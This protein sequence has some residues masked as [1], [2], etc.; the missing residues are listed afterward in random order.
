MASN[1]GSMVLEL[2]ANFA[3]F[4]SDMG[5]AAYIA[6]QNAEKMQRA[7][8]GAVDNVSGSLMHLAGNIVAAFSVEKLV[9]FGKRAI[10]TAD[11]V[12][13]MAQKIGISVESLSALQ[14]QARLSNTANEELQVGLSKLAKAAADA[15]GGGKQNQAVFAALGVSVKDAAGNL[16]PMADLLQDVAGKFATYR[17]SAAKTADAQL[18]F[19]KSG[20]NLIPYLNEL[21]QKSLPEVIAQAEQFGSVISTKTAKQAEA[22]NDNLT[23][24]KLEAEGFANAV[25]KQLLPNLVDLSN[26]MVEAGKT[27]DSYASSASTVADGV[28]VFVFSLIAAKEVVAALATGVFAFFDAVSTVFDS[29]GK[30]VAAWAETTAKAIKAAFSLDSAGLDA[31]DKEFADRVSKIGKGV[32]T[33]LKGA[34]EGLSGGVTD[35]VDRAKIAYNSLFNST[36]AAGTSAEKAG[37]KFGDA[38][39]PIIANAAAAD[40]A[41]KAAQKIAADYLDMQKVLDGLAAKLGGPYDKAWSEYAAAID[42]AQRASAKYTA[43]GVPLADV[44][45]FIAEATELATERFRELTSAELNLNKGMEAASQE[46][47]KQV[48][49]IG[50]T[51]DE[52]AIEAEYQKLLNI[53]LKE[54]SAVMGPLTEEEQKRLEGLHGM[55]VGLVELKKSTDLSVEA[56]KG[57]QNIWSQA[58]DSI[59][60]TFSKVLIEGGSFMKGLADIAKQVVEQI[61]AYFA[62]LAIINPILNSVFGGQAGFS[63]LPMWSGAA[64]G[65]GYA[66][67]GS[68]FGYGS[69]VGALGGA[70]AGAFAGYNAFKDAGGGLSGAAAGAAYGVGTFA[71]GGALSAGIAASAAG[72]ISAGL[73][74]GFAAIPVV[75]WVALAAMGLNMITGGGLFGTA[76]KAYGSEFNVGV[77]EGGAQASALVDLK[78]KKALFGG[79]YY[80]TQSTPVDQATQDGLNSFFSGL[81]D[82]ANAQAKAF[83]EDVGQIV[84]G[85]FHETFDKAGKMLTEVSTVAGVQ[86]KE[87]IDDF[88]KRVIGETLLGNMGAA[89]EEASKIAEQWRQSA[90]DLLAGSQFLAQAQLDINQG[91]GL[92][93]EDTLTQ[94]TTFVQGMEAQGESLIQTYVRLGVQTTTVE[95]ILANLGIST[96]KAGEALVEFDDAMVK[97]AGGLDNLNTLW[98]NYY[99]EFY[100]AAE[101]QMLDQKQ[102]QVQFAAIGQ[103]PT[104]TLAQFRTNFEQMLSTLTPEQVIAWLQAGDALAKF[105]SEIGNT[106]DAAASSAQSL[107]DSM[108]KSADALKGFEADAA[109]MA[110]T[111]F[112][113]QLDQLKARRDKY[114]GTLEFLPQ[115]VALDKQI[116]A[117]EEQQ[118][119][120]QRLSD[121][122]K[123]LNDFANIGAYTGQSLSQLENQFNVPAELLQQ[124]LGT[125]AEGLQS[126]FEKAEAIASA[127]LLIQD[128]TKLT[129]EYLADVVALLQGNALPYSTGDLSSAEAGTNLAVGDKISRGGVAGPAASS[130]VVAAVNTSSVQQANNTDRLATILSSIE[131]AL[132][133]LAAVSGSIPPNDAR[134]FR[135]TILRQ[136]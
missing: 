113:D 86:Y 23:S 106:A 32:A 31:A 54:M 25:A 135:T 52:I 19:G 107:M 136:P 83:G 109:S 30:L 100:S 11:E 73:A 98:N 40:K 12:G 28:K 72:G 36:E 104:E 134:S 2:S 62:K 96:G 55:A 76:A 57:W 88:Q 14:V 84:G 114:A 87:S 103:D 75:G 29:A 13:K 35:A 123:L 4:E 3:R 127:S 99:S 5:K 6:Q 26:Q 120:A 119:A 102:L 126:Q 51:S 27:T 18:L 93:P 59:A 91:H 44:Q 61:I 121:A 63:Q 124:Y 108:S 77:T 101:K 22:F 58:G 20:A 21:G 74:A 80:K 15:A 132:R 105:N 92:V 94:L 9:E 8:Q 53:A 79:S 133:D 38:A 41:E 70:A 89:S 50:Q 97:A 34:A 1:L 122:S 60:N 49:L 118:A 39:A 95:S 37:K 16:R 56:A 7:V 69:G 46:Y 68:S 116:A 111:L 131:G 67:A 71:I 82:A 125:N 90:T 115:T 66:G 128:N 33:A 10:D 64:G 42:Q 43:D 81:T 117:I 110:K 112:G 78:G 130:D 24:L 65:A 85:T 48:D 45:K 129:A 47:A 17:D